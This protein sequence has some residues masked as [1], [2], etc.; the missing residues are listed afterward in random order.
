MCKNCIYEDKK[1][2]KAVEKAKANNPGPFIEQEQ[3]N[4]RKRKHKK[5]IKLID[6]ILSCLA[7]AAFIIPAYSFFFLSP[8]FNVAM[9]MNV[10]IIT[11]IALVKLFAIVNDSAFWNEIASIDYRLYK[12]QKKELAKV[13]YKFTA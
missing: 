9:L 10:A 13:G 3:V 12:Q 1:Y 11:I 8:Y 5:I 2:L 7:I 6:I 4:K